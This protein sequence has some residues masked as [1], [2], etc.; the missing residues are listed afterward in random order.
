[1]KVLILAAGYGTRLY[2]LTKNIPK[3]LLP[4]NGTPIIEYILINLKNI[5]LEKIFIV[6][7]DQFCDKF[8]NWIQNINNSEIKELKD[9]IEII[10]DNTT[11]DEDKLGAIGDIDY[12]IKEK[13]V[14]DDLMILAADNLYNFKLSDFI[15]FSKKDNYPTIGITSLE[16]EKLVSKY[17]VVQVGK[18]NKVKS[19]EEKPEM[20]P[21]NKV[22]IGI[23]FLP[24]CSFILIEKYL[25]ERN[26]PDAIGFLIEWMCKNYEVYCY[27]FKGK[28]IDIGSKEGYKL[29]GGDLV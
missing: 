24:Q 14:N 28:W 8:K 25:N 6:T 1:M 22:A 21:T 5:N 13:E 23:Y 9:K 11:S 3:A 27:D 26:N 17:G 2:P 29:A 4:V 7:N 10:N 19:F 20:P 16:N 18:N 15:N 12:V